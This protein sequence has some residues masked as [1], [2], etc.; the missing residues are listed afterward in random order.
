MS[1]NPQVDTVEY[2]IPTPSQEE[3][4]DLAVKLAAMD[5]K[6]EGVTMAQ[7]RSWYRGTGGGHLLARLATL[8]KAGRVKSEM[9]GGAGPV[10]F[11]YW[12]LIE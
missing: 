11:Q 4:D 1:D 9:R 10:Q 8:E 6:K 12:T 3:L 5:S 2:T 7:V